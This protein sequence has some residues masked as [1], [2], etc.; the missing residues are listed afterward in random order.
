MRNAKYYLVPNGCMGL[1][2]GRYVLFA[3]ENEYWEAL[4]E[5][6]T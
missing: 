2:G 4:R 5:D 1:I 6:E 3:T